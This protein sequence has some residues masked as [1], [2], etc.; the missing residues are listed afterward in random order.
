M[1]P[2][3]SPKLL[4]P[5]AEPAEGPAAIPLSAG[6]IGAG[7]PALGLD[8]FGILGTHYLPTDWIGGGEVNRNTPE[9]FPY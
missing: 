9:L 7:W 3:P 1:K 5:A 2:C 4:R 8:D 6:H